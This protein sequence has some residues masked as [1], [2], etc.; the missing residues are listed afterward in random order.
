M[1]KKG[2]KTQAESNLFVGN[3]AGQGAEGSYIIFLGDKAGQDLNPN[4]IEYGETG[5]HNYQFSNGSTANDPYNYRVI[6]SITIYNQHLVVCLL[7][8]RVLVT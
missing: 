3:F 5:K 4:N 2:G 1:L 6:C 7:L 8:Q